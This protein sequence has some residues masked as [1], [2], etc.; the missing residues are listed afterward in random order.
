[1]NM[2]SISQQIDNRVATRKVLNHPF[3]QAW[4][5]GELSLD[6]LRDY[7][8]QYYKHVQAF[9]T[10][11]SAVHA[12]TDEIEVRRHLLQNLVDEEAGRPNHPE[13]WLQF[14]ASL[15]ID[16]GQAETAET[17]PETEAMIEVFR[18]ICRN[19]STAAGV[20]ALYAYESQIPEVSESK[21]DG[22]KR[23]YGFTDPEAYRYFTVH[24]E[25]DKEHAAVERAVIDKLESDADASEVLTAV[26]RVLESLYALL[27]GVCDRHNIACDIAAA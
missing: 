9:P 15:G 8:I 23:F 21:I 10:Y 17:R 27:S 19:G 24:I 22:L 12:H 14:V 18:D 2:M 6:A 4:N 11:L 25:A 16:T 13:L 7:A 3:Y 1:M 20:A 5:R 26:E